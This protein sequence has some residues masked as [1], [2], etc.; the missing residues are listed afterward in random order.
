[1]WITCLLSHTDI[2]EM[3]L[4]GKSLLS[5]PCQWLSFQSQASLSVSII[6]LMVWYG[7]FQHPVVWTG[8]QLRVWWLCSWSWL[9]SSLALCSKTIHR[10]KQE[11]TRFREE[12][13]NY[14]VNIWEIKWHK[15]H[16][17]CQR[18]LH[19]SLGRAQQP[20]KMTQKIKRNNESSSQFW[21]DGRM[22]LHEK[23]FV[24]SVVLGGNEREGISLQITEFQ[25]MIHSHN[26][27]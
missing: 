15:R 25:W 3:L 16:T 8:V 18:V 12:N 6:C 9:V 21:F 26:Q 7:L 4:P 2:L 17:G 27:E 1:M 24:L 11:R 5:V 19:C 14:W 23:V 13:G 10:A 22:N 20:I